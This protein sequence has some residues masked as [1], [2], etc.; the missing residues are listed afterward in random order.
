M[1]EKQEHLLK[2]FQELDHICQENEL[3]YVLAEESTLAAVGRAGFAGGETEIKV[4]MPR[5]DWNRLGEMAG[6]EL[7]KDRILYP[8]PMA[9]YGEDFGCALE[10]QQILG[11]GPAG[12]RIH[13]RILDPVSEEAFEKYRRD[14]GLYL[15]LTDSQEVHGQ[16]WGISPSRYY[17][18][19]LSGRLTGKKHVLGKLEKRMQAFREEDCSKFAVHV[20]ERF[21]FMEKE[22]LFPGKTCDFQG[23][24]AMIPGKASEYLTQVYGD[25]WTD[26]Q[27]P[28]EDDAQR[29]ATVEGICY[30]ELR[31]DYLPGIRKGRLQR[32]I[33]HSK[34]RILSGTKDSGQEESEGFFRNVTGIE[35]E[36]DL[37]RFRHAIADY[38]GGKKPSAKET[39][40]SLHEK[41]PDHL[42][43]TRFLGRFYMEEARETQ[44]GTEAERFIEEALRKFPED[45]YFLKY[46]GEL[47]WMR[48]RCADALVVFAQAREKTSNM[49][50]HKELD[51]F[52]ALYEQQAGD[53]C[54]AL[55]AN[56]EKEAARNLA[57]LWFRLLP[58]S[59]RMKSLVYLT[60]VST[61]RTVKEM[62]LL[63]DEMTAFVQVRENGRRK[64]NREL[65]GP[66]LTKAWE[67]LGYPGELAKLRTEILYTEEPGELEWIAEKVKDYQIHKDKLAQVYKLAGDARK[68]QGQTEQAFENYRKAMEYAGKSYARK[69]LSSLILQ[70]LY[71]GSH[72]AAEYAASGKG[73]EFLDAWLSRYGT[74]E[75]LKKL[76]RSCVADGSISHI[77]DRMPLTGENWQTMEDMKNPKT[78]YATWCWE[79]VQFCAEK[80]RLEKYYTTHKDVIVNLYKNKDF[81]RLESFLAPYHQATLRSLKTQEIFVPD[82]EIFEIYLYILGCKGMETLKKEIENYWN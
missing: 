56:R 28:A 5:A 79:Y 81:P 32:A 42:Q 20:G 70:D 19:Y 52:L 58:R 2:L 17:R 21:L 39:A 65:Y 15:D 27:F 31:E 72:K 23:V 55:L 69:E 62:E 33:M 76:V 48:G 26:F 36:K 41:Y 38:A 40:L 63:T 61:A 49:I 9:G 3:R 59:E 73:E 4:Y 35:Q 68:K 64:K 34:L 37:E 1:T 67:R 18:Y 54:Q 44:D 51:L 60:R 12:E 7:P 66:A 10:K 80:I 78:D 71:M 82:E 6:K 24:Q 8:E 11:T 50:V 47:L 46:R 13:I 74:V 45:G 57:E 14:L 22:I 43:I 29:S 25:E 30:Q 75:D 77:G 53:T 16:S